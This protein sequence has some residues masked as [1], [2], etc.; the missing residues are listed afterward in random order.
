MAKQPLGGKPVLDAEITQ[1]TKWSQVWPEAHVLGRK[2]IHINILTWNN[3][4]RLPK[5]QKEHSKWPETK[6]LLTPGTNIL[7]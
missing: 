4:G 7:L 5:Q 6:S 2:N 3:N 1:N